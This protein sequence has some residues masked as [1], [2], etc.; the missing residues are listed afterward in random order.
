MKNS[1]F[2]IASLLLLSLVVC[3]TEPAQ[4][5]SSHS[6]NGSIRL[7]GEY[8]KDIHDPENPG[9]IVDPGES[10]STDGLLRIEFVPQLNFWNNQISSEDQTYSANAQLFHSDTGPRGNFIQ[11]SDYRGTGSGWTLQLKQETQ[12]TNEN[13]ENKELTGAMISFDRSWVNSTFDLSKAPTV[14]KDVIR[15]ENIGHTYNLATAENGKGEGTWSIE[16]GASIENQNGQTD[17]LSPR[18]D[19]EGNPYLDATFG[20]RP[21]YEN[22]A[23]TLFVPGKTKKDPVQYQTVLTW[24]LSELP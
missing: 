19:A 21:I 13:T 18:L 5:E 24:I 15:I 23:V 2:Y 8:G 4:A 20:N 3:G 12:F 10:P 1:R 17:T 9:T 11:V 22:S 14:S 6:G 7:E 16:F